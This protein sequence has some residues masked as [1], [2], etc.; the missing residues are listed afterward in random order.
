MVERDLIKNLKNLR[1]IKPD[2]DWALFCRSELLKGLGESQK[3]GSFKPERVASFVNPVN[4]INVL[5][6]ANQFV[7]AAFRLSPAKAAVTLTLMLLMAGGVGFYES[8]E[9]LPRSA[10][11]TL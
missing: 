2:P 8:H 9:S 3:E 4:L 11:F 1:Q 6:F 7:F 10:V 5:N